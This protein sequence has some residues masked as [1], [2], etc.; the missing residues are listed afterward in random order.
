MTKPYKV[1]VISD[2]HIPNHSERSLAVLEQYMADHTWDEVIYLG[3]FMD[4]DCIS[5]HN[6]DNLRGVMGKTIWKD[7][8][9]AVEILDRHQKLCPKAKFVLIEGNHDYRIERYIDA[10]PQLQGMIEVE[11]GLEL[12]KRKV[13]WVRFWSK[14][15]VYRV[16]KASFIHGTYT[17][18]YHAKKHLDNYDASI[19]YGHVHSVQ[20]HTKI[21]RKGNPMI[22]QSLGCL[23]NLDQGYMRGKPSNWVHAFGVIHFREG[24][25]FTPYVITIVNHSFTSPEGKTYEG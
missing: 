6:K 23:C 9:A 10:N 25:Y 24:G 14:G 4:F 2:L 3:D 7:Y 11:L 17:N 22:A 12:I 20:S 13:K 19:F 5:H 21:Q 15:D 1:L 18:Q 16:G 8:D